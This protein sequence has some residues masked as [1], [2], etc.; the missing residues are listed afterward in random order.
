MVSDI[1]L[2]NNYFKVGLSFLERQVA[3]LFSGKGVVQ[4]VCRSLTRVRK[5]CRSSSKNRAKH[6]SNLES[7]CP[8]AVRVSSCAPCGFSARVVS[9]YDSRHGLAVHAACSRISAAAWNPKASHTESHVSGE[10]LRNE[11]MG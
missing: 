9:A 10:V 4:V 8:A 5:V 11:T 1:N 7:Q 6:F 2:Q 3:Q